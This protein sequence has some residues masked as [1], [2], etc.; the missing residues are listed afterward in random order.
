MKTQKGAERENQRRKTQRK[1]PKSRLTSGRIK[2]LENFRTSPK[3]ESY[4]GV[5]A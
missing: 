4:Q 1:M 3:D 5:Q 2:R